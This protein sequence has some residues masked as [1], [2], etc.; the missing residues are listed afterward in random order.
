MAILVVLLAPVAAGSV[1]SGVAF[2]VD[3]LGSP[4]RDIFIALAVI[5]G[6]IAA[7]GAAGHCAA[8][9]P[10][11]PAIRIPTTIVVVSFACLLTLFS[12]FFA[13][14]VLGL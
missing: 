12:W 11:H 7:A 1:I 6:T 10:W 14:A 4:G 2:A 5:A 13:N 3:P 9:L 8:R